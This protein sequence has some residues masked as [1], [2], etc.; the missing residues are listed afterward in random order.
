MYRGYT[1]SLTILLAFTIVRSPAMGADHLPRRRAERPIPTARPLD[2]AQFDTLP[3][4]VQ[5]KQD[6]RM[7]PQ[8]EGTV[9]RINVA[10]GQRVKEGE[11]LA[12]IDNRVATAA[13]ELAR[14]TAGRVAAIQHA[15]EELSFSENLLSRLLALKSANAGSDFE[16]LE[17]RSRV[18]KA[19]ASLA[20]ALEEKEQAQR[21]LELESA[22]LER[23]NIRAPFG[24]QIVA[25]KADPGT[26]LTRDDELLT[27]I[28]LDELEVE[29]HVPLDLYNRLQV[30]HSYTLLA[31]PPLNHPLSAQLTFAAPVVNAATHTFR[32]IFTIDNHNL[33]LPAGFTVKLDMTSPSLSPSL[34]A[35][36]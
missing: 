23:F 30:G 1:L 3:G 27:L 28:Q 9:M 36:P 2:T 4:V 16:L 21:N 8:T 26:T 24:G 12:Q 10:E 5:P 20:A 18:T 13:V 25:V 29:L 32:T 22:K 31:G 35:S 11:I 15:R 7:A 6:V 34:T 14:I 33:Q 19:Q 17:A